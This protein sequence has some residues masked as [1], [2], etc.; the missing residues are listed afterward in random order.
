M[1]KRF[2]FKSIYA[3]FAFIF[4]G[5]WWF[6]NG[7]TFGVV[8]R[9]IHNTSLSRATFREV[10]AYEEFRQIRQTT[11]L[12]FVLSVT[13]GTVLILLAVRSVVKPIR[14]ISKASKE[15]ARG[16]FDIS[17]TPASRDE[18]GQLTE[19]FNTMAK[20]LKNIETLQIDFV[21]NV[22]HEFKTPVTAITGYARLIQDGGLAPEQAS[23]YGGII[24]SEGERLSVLSEN[25]LRL[26]E[27]DNGTIREQDTAFS[28]DEQLR[29]TVLL[30]EP[31]WSRKGIEWALD[32]SPVRVTANEPLLKEV[33]LNL[34]HNA[35]KFSHTGGTVAIN[36]SRRGQ[37]VCVTVAD[38]G[39]GISPRESEH[40]FERFYKADP[41]RSRGGNGLGL[42]IARKIVDRTGGTITFESE[43]GKGASFT[44]E[45]PC[46]TQAAVE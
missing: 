35:V 12:T 37:T 13:L 45:L 46:G 27:L 34:I 26:S 30:L 25:L 39:I 10:I 19:D 32:L 22:S 17:I 3:K 28:L 8:M 6:M 41:S 5:I 40:L 7:V 14:R 36:M 1:K 31:Q 16:N 11:M 4:L 9:I 20:E 29:Q 15:I 23:E 18:I 24:R 38:S 42:V 33:W 21:A 2:G 44:V 43:P